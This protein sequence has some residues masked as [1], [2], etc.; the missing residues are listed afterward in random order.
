MDDAPFLNDRDRFPAVG[1]YGN[2]RLQSGRF[3]DGT[4]S[5]PSIS[6]N[7]RLTIPQTGS[8]R[9][10]QSM[11]I[12]FDVCIG[13]PGKEKSLRS[14]SSTESQFTWLRRHARAVISFKLSADLFDTSVLHDHN[15][16]SHGHGFDPA[17]NRVATNPVARRVGSCHRVLKSASNRDLANQGRAGS[18]VQGV[19]VGFP[20][21]ST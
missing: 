17:L 7:G 15:P 4:E 10:G 16:A 14:C 19:E 13:R 21:S 1:T 5:F 9:K 12:D 2:V 3:D 6:E 8:F 20:L 11:T 18:A